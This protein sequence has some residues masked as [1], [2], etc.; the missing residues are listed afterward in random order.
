MEPARVLC[1]WA[2]P[3]KNTGIKIQIPRKIV[4]VLTLEKFLVR[5]LVIRLNHTKQ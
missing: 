3:G 1:P 5:M 4:N 2:F